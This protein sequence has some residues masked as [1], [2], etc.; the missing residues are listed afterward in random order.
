MLAT[1]QRVSTACKICQ[2][3]LCKQRR[4]DMG[5]Y[6]CWDIWHR[7]KEAFLQRHE[8]HILAKGNLS[9]IA[10]YA[11]REFEPRPPGWDLSQET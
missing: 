1:P 6:S 9:G 11:S 7:D 2:V 4:A 5:G 8:E 10:C 3:V